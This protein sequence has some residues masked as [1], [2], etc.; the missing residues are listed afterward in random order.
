LQEVNAD[1]IGLQEVL[2]LPDASPEMDQARYFAEALGYHLI[3]GETRKIRGGVYGNVLLTRIPVVGSENYDI[4][5]KYREQRGCLRVDL[6]LEERLLLHVF[7]L[8]LGTIFY[9]RRTQARKLVHHEILHNPELHGIR[10]V[11][12]DFNEWRPGYITRLFETH[13]QKAGTRAETP[14]TYPAVHPTLTLDHIYFDSALRPE[15]ITVHQTP[16]AL[17][18]SDHLPLVVDLELHAPAVI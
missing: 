14:R 16:A 13:F 11:M 15:R 12:G 3:V 4:S 17:R 1:I 18:A 10:V 5:V 6:Q 2:S 8:H 7:N 9:E